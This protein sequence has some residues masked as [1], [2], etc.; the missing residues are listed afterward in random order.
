MV[1]AL[2]AAGAAGAAV[3]AAGML[4]RVRLSRSPAAPAVAAA[5]AGA[6]GAG[7]AGGGGSASWRALARVTLAPDRGLA[8][9]A[10]A[11]LV[12]D[13]G[14]ALAAPW[15]LQLVVDYGLGGRRPPAW[16]GW[17][18]GFAPLPLAGAAAAAGLLVLAAGALAGYQVTYLTGALTERMALRLRA[19]LVAHLLRVPPAAVAGYPLGELTSR[20]GADVR[21]VAGVIGTVIETLVPDLAL[22]A[23][24]AV[25]TAA[26]DWRLTLIVAALV[27]LYAAAA[28]LRNASLRAAQ[29][30]A[31]ARAGELAALTAAQ[32]ARLPAIAVFGHGGAEARRHAAAAGLAADAEVAAIDA[33]ARFRPAHDLLPGLGLAATLVAGTAE[34]M[35]GRLTVGG[36]L[37]FLA[38]LSSL[39]GPVRSLSAL[40]GTIARGSASRDRIAELLAL[41]PAGPRRPDGLPVAGTVPARGPRAAGPPAT[42]RRGPE[43]RFERVCFARRPGTPVLD[44]VSFSLPAGSLT[45]LTGPSGAG[46]S[47]LLSLIIRLADPQH[48][49]ILA[50]GTDIGGLDLGDLRALVT[51]VP[52]DP[53]LHEGTIAENIA[54]GR[55]GAT[56]VQVAAAARRAG[57]LAFAADLPDGLDAP[58]GEHGR[59]LSAGQRRRV[60]VAR[61]LLR[62]APALLLD[63]PTAGLDP[64]T[65]GRLISEVLD[66]ARGKTILLVT[67]DAGLA[68]LAD[69]VLTLDRG[70]VTAAARGAS[71]GTQPPAGFAA[72][73]PSRSFHGD[74]PDAPQRLT[75]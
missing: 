12:T 19:R 47:T 46:K 34:V 36:L 33:S 56:R 53:W 68:P 43:I 41:P 40:T 30:R 73:G 25:V 59:L 10:L 16:L 51:L 20:I 18:A 60:A 9:L 14:L 72:P 5:D 26:I 45:V 11:V 75:A 24:M 4:A 39:T 21:Q 17:S 27:P 70:T 50:D 8:A 65:A 28:R 35:S 48:G 38:Y 2:I 64:R 32:L 22:L 52:Q 74:S 58:A 23:G 42:P 1:V 61:A 66:A 3:L 71:R 7:A 13:T 6:A 63:E 55:P 49:R 29:R 37:V 67:H 57:V 62:D 31:R 44:E 15:P 69:Q 54:Y